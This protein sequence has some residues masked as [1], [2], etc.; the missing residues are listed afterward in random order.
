MTSDSEDEGSTN[1][2]KPELPKSTMEDLTSLNDML[3]G[4]GY[5]KKLVSSGIGDAGMLISCIFI[6]F[7]FLQAK[8]IKFE[9]GQTERI[10]VANIIAGHLGYQPGNDVQT[11]FQ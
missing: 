10:T 11:S 5:Q 1:F 4:A 8:T 7:F 3:L 6:K 9:T 2:S